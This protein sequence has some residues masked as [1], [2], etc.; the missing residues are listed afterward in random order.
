[1]IEIID[2]GAPV[3]PFLKVGDR[4]EIQLRDASGADIFGS[5]DQ[6]VVPA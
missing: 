6:K 1:M 2:G 3:T 4:V 5:I